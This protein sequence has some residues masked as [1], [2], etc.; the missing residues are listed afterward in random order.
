MDFRKHKKMPKVGAVMTPFPYSARPTDNVE[1]VERLM[2]EHEIRHI[3]VQDD[4][5]VVGIVSERDLHALAN[6]THPKVDKGRIR[7]R[8]VALPNPYVVEI[9]MPLDQVV[10]SMAENRIGSAIVVKQGKLVGILSVTDICRVLA[11]LLE[12]RFP[13]PSGDDVA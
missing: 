9:D 2:H 7:V 12:E 4:G 3:P 1:K 8:D 13:A 11:E 6:P 5:R 10:T